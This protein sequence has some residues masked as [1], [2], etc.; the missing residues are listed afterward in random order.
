LNKICRGAFIFGL[1]DRLFH[2]LQQLFERQIQ[3]GKIKADGIKY[4]RNVII[5]MNR[6]SSSDRFI[7]YEETSTQ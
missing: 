3:M 1:R 6:L 7:K 4:V 5:Y 2:L